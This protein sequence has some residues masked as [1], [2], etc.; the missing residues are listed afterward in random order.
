MIDDKHRVIF[1]HIPKTGGTTIQ[2]TLTSQKPTYDTSSRAQKRRQRFS[3]HTLKQ[4]A[5]ENQ[6]KFDAYYKFSVVR[7]PWEREYSFFR[8]FYRNFGRPFGLP[9]KR[10]P[11]HEQKPIPLPITFEKYLAAVKMFKETGD[12]TLADRLRGD[13]YPFMTPRGKVISKPPSQVHG[14]IRFKD[15]WDFLTIDGKLKMD[16]IIY[17]E[18]LEE[19]YREVCSAIDKKYIPLPHLRKGNYSRK[20]YEKAYTPELVEL[21]REIRK[22]DIEEFGYSF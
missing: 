17:F 1:V 7:N 20:A 3:H 15:Q 16:K 9:L 14:G 5:A 21:V 11:D 12:R 8:F 18:E 4:Y 13:L 19:G 10:P 2:S 6:K 22:K